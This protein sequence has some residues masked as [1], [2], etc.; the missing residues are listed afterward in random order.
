MDLLLKWMTPLPKAPNHKL[1]LGFPFYGIKD[2]VKFN[3]PQCIKLIPV[4]AGW[5]NPLPLA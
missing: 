4:H 2:H 1:L 5:V 3:T